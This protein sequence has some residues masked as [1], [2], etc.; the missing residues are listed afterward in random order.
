ML[1]L[2]PLRKGSSAVLDFYQRARVFNTQGVLFFKFSIST[3]NIRL[4]GCHTDAAHQ[5]RML[6][7]ELVVIN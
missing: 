7:V 6:N 2:A 5:Q 1:F 4:F 3:C